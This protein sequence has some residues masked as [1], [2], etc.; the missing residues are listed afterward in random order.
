M[1][2]VG[3]EAPNRV[4]SYLKQTFTYR[5]TQ[6]SRLQILGLFH[7]AEQLRAGELESAFTGSLHSGTGAKQPFRASWLWAQAAQSEVK[8]IKVCR[9]SPGPQST[10]TTAA[11]S[12]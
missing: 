9:P 7:W 1:L 2:G 12:P 11:F 5:H 3:L 10:S 6:E 8:L 4:C